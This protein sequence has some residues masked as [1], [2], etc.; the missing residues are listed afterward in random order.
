MIISGPAAQ[1]PRDYQQFARLIPNLK[2]DTDYIIEEKHRAVSLTSEGISK[3]EKLLKLDN[4]Y[5]PANVGTVHFVENALK[6]QAVFQRDQD[7]VVKDGEVVL[8][9]EFTGRLMPGRRLSDGLHQAIEAKGG[10]QGPAREHHLRHD[11]AAEL[12]PPVRQAGGNDGHGGDG[13]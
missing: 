13:S 1:S 9:D 11:H 12:L 6:A 3:L 5:A 10:R 7:Y 4:L 2:L 8:V